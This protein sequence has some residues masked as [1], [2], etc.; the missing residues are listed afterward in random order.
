MTLQGTN[1]GQQQQVATAVVSSSQNCTTSDQDNPHKEMLAQA[2]E[3]SQA[4]AIGASDR[5]RNRRE[6][7]DELEQTTE[8]KKPKNQATT[9]HK[10][11]GNCGRMGHK[12]AVCVKT[13]PSGW[14]EA[15]PKCNTKNHIYNHCPQRK[16]AEDFTYLIFNRQRKPPVKCEFRLD[17]VIR[18]EIKSPGSPWTLDSVI[19]LPYTARFARRAARENPPRRW[20]YPY[21]EDP[22]KE[23]GLREAPLGMD[24]IT[25]HTAVNFIFNNFLWSPE[26]EKFDLMTDEEMSQPSSAPSNRP[27][28]VIIRRDKDFTIS[29]E[30]IFRLTDLA[31]CALCGELSHTG[32]N[33]N[34]G[35]RVCVC[36]RFPGHKAERCTA[37]CLYCPY[38]SKKN[39]P[40]RMVECPRLCHLCLESG[41]L[42]RACRKTDRSDTEKRH[43]VTCTGGKVFHFPTQCIQNICPIRNCEDP[44]RCTLHCS[45]CGWDL[46]EDEI[47]FTASKQH[48]TCLFTK[49]WS[50][51]SDEEG[52]HFP[53]LIC[54]KNSNHRVPGNEELQSR[55]CQNR[56]QLNIAIKN[57]EEAILWSK[58]CPE[59][60]AD[61]LFSKEASL[62]SDLMARP[63]LLPF[64]TSD[65]T[66]SVSQVHDT[67]TGP[68]GQE[69]SR[70]GSQ[71]E[72]D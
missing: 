9:P 41:H 62:E 42:T 72:E 38:V 27:S 40:H 16:A 69:V 43:C 29:K 4:Q 50:T 51:D 6:S 24:N 31:P 68:Y 32:T 7:S 14:M 13:G 67:A 39:V 59:C 11:C 36:S 26:A 47:I 15:C 2:I 3:T 45:D 34:N 60:L 57:R 56:V 65:L 19:Q 35:P 33:C 20:N 1:A 17:R 55:R 28:G 21:P 58:E 8:H 49:A 53:V 52:N 61:D 30:E 46:L 63:E 18:K 70:K 22:I 23:A 10:H 12:A 44:A 37:W 71:E 48:H 54:K 25:L 64:E 66:P 5:K